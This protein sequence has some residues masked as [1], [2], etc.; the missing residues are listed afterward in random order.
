MKTILQAI[1]LAPRFLFQIYFQPSKVYDFI[2]VDKKNKNIYLWSSLFQGLFLGT[3]MAVPHYLWYNN[4]VYSI[5]FAVAFVGAV[6]VAVAVAGGFVSAVLFVFAVGLAFAFVDLFTSQEL[7]LGAFIVAS[8][9][10]LVG[11]IAGKQ[12]K[13]IPD[14]LLMIFINILIMAMIALIGYG[15]VSAPLINFT[16]QLTLPIAYVT[17]Y[18]V[19]SSLIYARRQQTFKTK[20][21]ESI[22]KYKDLF[23]TPFRKLLSWGLLWTTLL[24]ISALI[25]IFFKGNPET[26]PSLKI[27]SGGFLILS[28][29]I[30]HIPDYLLCLPV[31]RYQRRRMLK[32][33][34]TPEELM[35]RYQTSML[36]KHEML[37]FPLAGLD[38]V[39]VAISNHEGLGTKAVVKHITYLYLFTF[40]QKQALTAFHR[41]WQEKENRHLLVHYLLEAGNV[42][43]LETLAKDKDTP[44]PG[45]YLEL[46]AEDQSPP[47]PA[48]TLEQR[49]NRVCAALAAGEKNPL[50]DAM[51]YS[52]EMARQ[53]LGAAGIKDFYEAI[54]AVEEKKWAFPDELD[55]FS[56]LAKTFTQLIKINRALKKAD[57]I[58]RYET[59][60]DIFTGQKQQLEYLA[61]TT[62]AALYQPFA[63]IWRQALE[64]C[65]AL[66]EK[67]SGLLYGYA[68]FNIH[69]LEKELTPGIEDQTLHF[70]ITNTGRE[71]SRGVS[72]ELQARGPAL[73]VP[74]QMKQ[75]FDYIEI[76]Q[77][78]R[79]ALTISVLNPGKTTVEVM[80]TFSDPTRENKREVFSFPVTIAAKP[81][82]FKKIANP[83]IAGPALR[84][85][86][87]L[88]M[89]RDDIYRYV[90]ENIMPGSQHHT[91][92]C[93]GLRRTGKSSLLTR[94]EKQGFSNKGLIPIHIDLQGI[95][96]EKNFYLTL[97][98]KILQK[99]ALS[100]PPPVDDFSRFKRFIREIFPAGSEKK[101]VA[102]LDEFEELQMRVEDKSISRAIFSNLR[103]LMQYEDNI[104]FLFC[105]THKLEE[106]QA[107][108]WSIFFNTALYR[109][110]GKLPRADAVRLIKEPVK[111]R[112]NYH[113][114]AV[115]QILA[116]SGCQPY[117]I[118]L[119]CRTVVNRLNHLEKRNDA[120]ESDV[121]K[122][123]AQ[124]IET[125]GDNFSKETWQRANHLERLILSAAAG[126]LTRQPVET[127]N[128]EDLLAK[129]APLEPGF[130]R[131]QAVDTLDKLVTGEILAE[132]DL[133][134]CFRVNMTRQWIAARHPLSKVRG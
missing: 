85:D 112:V 133:N 31:W 111:D 115:E 82:A 43:M 63:H 122:A 116:M 128:L 127:V 4:S 27:I 131:E 134:Y 32:P 30:L 100:S 49:I 130:S 44:L 67:E 118:Q 88:F 104:I 53:L 54:A 98:E 81:A 1:K 55:Y 29:F 109:R 90:D 56:V 66:V 102:L 121:N 93:Q 26:F 119:L 78:K 83:Y 58:E 36:F 106:M 132:K 38:K 51:V 69:L 75:T 76:R 117:L 19:A 59:K 21:S 16:R 8:T 52:L 73:T 92:V 86:S 45:L 101:V 12:R 74:V 80:L 25:P 87:P 47:A 35:R 61:R 13:N 89:G 123:A 84:S 94:I 129:I 60:R 40:Q 2:K 72:I 48:Q 34:L 77:T 126:T 20:L 33:S 50:N 5:L 96:D 6:E 103:H 57:E 99:L 3:I 17:G 108:Y 105:G 9:F 10:S 91:I 110:I 46:L 114:L 107:D 79:I 62:P 65:A 70:D 68:E 15:K 18:I 97:S 113:H 124:I 64:H 125:D 42:P 24:A 95:G 23:S 41:L 120:L 22:V 37:Y 11:S 14:A 39:L 28:L 7:L 71:L